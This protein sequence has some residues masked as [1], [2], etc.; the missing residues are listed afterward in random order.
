MTSRV[1]SRRHVSYFETVFT[2]GHTEPCLQQET[3]LFHTLREGGHFSS[4]NLLKGPTSTVDPHPGLVS[5]E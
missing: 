3:G 2:L 1:S 4:L 5:E